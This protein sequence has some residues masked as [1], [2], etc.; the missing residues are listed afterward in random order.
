MHWIVMVQR[1]NVIDADLWDIVYVDVEAMSAQLACEDVALEK[2][3]GR[4]CAFPAEY[5]TMFTLEVE[6]IASVK[7]TDTFDMAK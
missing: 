5:G 6:K 1:Q 2:G 4:Y 7:V 3:E